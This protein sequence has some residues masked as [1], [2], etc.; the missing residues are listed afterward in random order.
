MTAKDQL[1]QELEQTPENIIEATLYFLRFAKAQHHAPAL[2]EEN[3]DNPLMDLLEEFDQFA[4][5]IPKEDRDTLPRDGAEQIDH[6]L[7]GTPRQ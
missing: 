4:A 7:Y 3:P 6:Y 2:S 5:N 1:L